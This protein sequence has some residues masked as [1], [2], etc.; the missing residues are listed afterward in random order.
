MSTLT[1]QF[2]DSLKRHLEKA[3]ASDGI[4][5]DQFVNLAV[6]E[7]LSALETC[8]LIAQRASQGSQQAFLAAMALVPKS[9]PQPGDEL[10]ADRA[11][12]SRLTVQH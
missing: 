3:A 5:V 1:L 10:P 8:D 9:A 4:S 12:Q 6:A 11:K 2:P 7:K